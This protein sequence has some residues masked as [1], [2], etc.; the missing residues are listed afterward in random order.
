MLPPRTNTV[1]VHTPEGI[2]VSLLLASPVTRFLASL[3]DLMVIMGS[4]IV[5]RYV[6][7]ALRLVSADF[8]TAVQLAGYFVISIGY[9]TAT[10]WYWPAETIGKPLLRVR[11]LDAQAL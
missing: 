2:T 3:V 6:T 10:E 8:A 5:L 11:V 7:S 1:R 4:M 9:G